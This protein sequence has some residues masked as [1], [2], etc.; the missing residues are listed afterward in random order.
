M[1]TVAKWGIKLSEG[2]IAECLLD[3]MSVI[4][5]IAQL[6]FNNTIA[7]QNKDLAVSMDYCILPAVLLLCLINKWIYW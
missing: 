2:D 3:E 5:I 4:E 6:F 1:H 7:C